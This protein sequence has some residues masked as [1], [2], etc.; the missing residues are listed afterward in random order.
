MLTFPQCWTGNLFINKVSFIMKQVFISLTQGQMPSH[1]I[2]AINLIA[3]L[4][5]RLLKLFLRLCFC[6]VFNGVQQAVGSECLQA[7]DLE[8]RP[9]SLCMPVRVGCQKVLI[10]QAALLKW[11]MYFNLVSTMKTLHNY[12][13]WHPLMRQKKRDLL[14]FHGTN[15]L[16]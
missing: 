7:P 1:L 15:V 13:S 2:K 9:N 12:V 10:P 3:A 8:N 11:K 16:L 4:C 5:L 14:L 6:L